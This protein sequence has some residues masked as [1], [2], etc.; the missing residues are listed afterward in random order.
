MSV[1]VLLFLCGFLGVAALALLGLVLA[2]RQRRRM[3]ARLARAGRAETRVVPTKGPVRRTRG[4][5]LPMLEQQMALAGL[6]VSPARLMLPFSV[7]VLG[8][9]AA[10]LLTPLHPVAGAV[11]AL[12]LP[13][14]AGR[15]WL[16]QVLARYRAGFTAGL[17]EALD[18][19]ARGLRAGRPVAD[20]LAIVVQNA[21]GPVAREFARCR[22]ALRLGTSLAECLARLNTRVPTPEV[23]FFAVATALQAETGGNLIET[24]ENLAHQLRER[25]K[26]RRK[27]R[28]LSSEARASA[29]I[30]A[31]LP[32]AVGLLL[33]VLN[34]GYLAPLWNDPRG[35]VMGLVALLSVG[36]GIALMVRMGKLDV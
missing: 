6:R 25:R 18:V 33:V 31:S 8:L 11:L 19:F 20:S 4:R 15:L 26:L 32:F 14:L 17:P 35:Q 10:L 22:D 30:L 7:A 3:A 16:A 13:S 36:T 9:Y 2:D 28:A 1:T 24:M 34:A 5:W 21:E 29:A 23:G 12:G 27:A